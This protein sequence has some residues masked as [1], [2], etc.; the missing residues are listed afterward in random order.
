LT[1]LQRASLCFEK[2]R[3]ILS[4]N[5]CHKCETNENA[6]GEYDKLVIDLVKDRIE[7]TLTKDNNIRDRAINFTQI[8]LVLMGI[9]TVIITIMVQYKIPLNPDRLISVSAVMVLATLSV[10]F[11]LIVIWP[12][13][14]SSFDIFKFDKRHH[15]DKLL[16]QIGTYIK[17]VE[18][19]IT[20]ME[21]NYD[22]KAKWLS[23]SIISFI[24]ALIATFLFYL[25]LIV[26]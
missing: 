11:C 16:Y 18:S 21:S 19:T 10:F 23:R 1:E 26:I 22:R 2:K 15:S 4:N 12:S 8:N 24:L 13:K 25:T 20:N 7:Q 3:K 9:V 14:L 6:I 5:Y 17:T